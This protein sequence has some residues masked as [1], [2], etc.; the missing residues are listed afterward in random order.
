MSSIRCSPPF[1]HVFALLLTERLTEGS[2][3]RG[4]S[5]DY[6]NLNTSELEDCEYFDSIAKS[7]TGYYNRRVIRDIRYGRS[8]IHASGLGLMFKKKTCDWLN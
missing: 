3:D 8:H 1:R 4:C 6:L 2:L 7:I 5:P